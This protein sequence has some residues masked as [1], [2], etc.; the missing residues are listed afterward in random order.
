MSQ[1][2]GASPGYIEEF[3]EPECEM[4]QDVSFQV[5]IQHSSKHL[6]RL[7]VP[8]VHYLLLD[9]QP[10]EQMPE[11]RLPVNLAIVFDC[12]TSMSGQRLD[13]VRSAVLAILED[14]KPEDRASVVAFS[15]RAEVIV[16][17]DQPKDSSLVRS[18]LR[19]LKPRGGTEIGQGLIAGMKEIH[20]NYSREGVN[21]IVLLSDG[22]TYGD[23]DLCM[24][25]ASDAAEQGITI[26]GVGIGT[27][28][29]HRVL[30]DLATKTGGSVT[31]LS[32]PK[33][34]TN[35]V[36]TI[37]D[38]MIV[39]NLQIIGALGEQVDLRS[40]FRIQPRPEMLDN[41]FPLTL[42]YLPREGK[43]RL[44]IELVVQPIIEL[45]EL[46]LAHINVSGDIL[47]VEGETQS[48]P[49]EINLPITDE[50]DQNPPPNDIISALNLVSLYKTQEKARRGA[51]LG[52]GV[53]AARRLENLA[54]H[55]LA[56]GERDLARAVL[57]EAVRLSR[58]QRLAAEAFGGKD[59]FRSDPD[60]R[61]LVEI[62][63]M[64][65]GIGSDLVLERGAPELFFSREDID[66]LIGFCE[67]M[68]S[69][70][71]TFSLTLINIDRFIKFFE[72][73]G[74]DASDQ[75]LENLESLF[76]SQLSESAVLGRSLLDEFYI[77]SKSNSLG[78]AKMRA[79]QIRQSIRTVTVLDSVG[80][81]ISPV[82]VTI[83]LAFYPAH[84]ANLEELCRTAKYALFVGKAR[85]GDCIVPP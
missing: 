28:W 76:R 85:G 26:N 60:M 31:Y 34:V 48:L 63:L 62:L 55:L 77:A 22:R 1:E 82:T 33:V 5:E 74:H 45:H 61:E 42:G 10:G 56:S 47:G 29:S 35:L 69:A 41:S 50:S 81:T 59:L 44:L 2:F 65:G 75:I 71:E 30:N 23:E 73:Y 38:S 49:V 80:R 64:R 24:E 43:L 32:A 79:D 39:S 11:V 40:A 20:R 51:K 36:R 54:T 46:T 70:H 67:E 66:Q 8:Q 21:H 3:I 9:I 72:R 52:Q 84:G 83:G 19:Q 17:P 25:I 14:M 13:A 27:G 7:D 37:C 68:S 78:G 15:D 16:T 18:R 57:N 4:T 53:Q 6:A 12:S 58:T